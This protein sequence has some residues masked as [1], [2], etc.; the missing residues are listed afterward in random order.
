MFVRRA[1]DR[2]GVVDVEPSPLALERLLS[3]LQSLPGVHGTSTSIVLSTYKETREV[4][5]R[6]MELFQYEEQAEP[7]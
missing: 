6:P 4:A 3:V 5:V 1:Q 7:A 2:R